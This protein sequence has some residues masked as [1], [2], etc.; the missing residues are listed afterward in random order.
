MTMRE[1]QDLTLD[2]ARGVER[3]DTQFADRAKAFSHWLQHS[4]PGE[5]GGYRITAVPLAS[6]SNIPRI[7]NRPSFPA[8]HVLKENG[9]E[10]DLV[11]PR[12]GAVRP[13][14]RGIRQHSHDNS[15]VVDML[16]SGLVDFWHH[17][18]LAEGLHFQL[19]WLFAAYLNVLDRV[20]WMRSVAEAP[21]WEFAIEL[22][23]GI[24]G[25]PHQKL[26]LGVTYNPRMTIELADLPTTF[27]RVPFRDRSDR[28]N[29]LN[30]VLRDLLDYVGELGDWPRIVL[31]A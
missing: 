18:V 25:S 1:I 3:L 13:I 14:I 8:R 20:D 6:L 24:R 10:T 4:P 22:G 11:V 9:T 17:S 26:M 12:H 21:D 16:Q 31:R 28:E 2:F 7:V 15:V 5:R 30:L 27:P 19:T 29:I 23:L